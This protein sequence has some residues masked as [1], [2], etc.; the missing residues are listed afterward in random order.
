L[1]DLDHVNNVGDEIKTKIKK[2]K[3]TYFQFITL[4]ISSIAPEGQ[5]L[6]HTND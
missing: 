2:E 6:Q 1:I 5:I 3:K 4:L